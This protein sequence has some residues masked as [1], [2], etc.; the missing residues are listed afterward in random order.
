MHLHKGL[1]RLKYVQSKTDP[2]LYYR[3][4]T[5]LAIYI[6]DCILIAKTEKLVTEA[7][8]E[9]SLNF[10]ITDEGEVDEYLGV[11]IEVLKDKRVKMSQPF[12]IDQILSG[13]GFNERTKPKK[14]PAVSSKILH[15]DKGG[16]KMQTT[17][18]YRRIIGQLNFLEKSTRPDIAYA[19]HQCARF[20]SDPR[21]SHKMAILRIGRYL[22]ATRSEGIVFEPDNSSLELWC[23]ADFSGNWRE[24]IAHIDR[25][26]AK[27]RTG[28]VV[29]YAGC[30]LTWASKMQTE[31]ALSTT[32]AE[33]IALSEG[34]RTV[35]PIMSLLE[36]MQEQGVNITK[37][38][39]DIKCK[40]FEDNSGA[41]TIAT[42]PKI[43]PRTK[44]INT[45]YWHFREHM[46]Q[47]K[48]ALLPVST[49][50]QIADI[51]TKPLPEIDFVKLKERIMG[52]ER[53]HIC[54][55]SKG[56]VE[57]N[58]HGITVA[59]DKGI[60]GDENREQN[61]ARFKTGANSA[62][63]NANSYEKANDKIK[64][65]TMLQKLQKGDSAGH[66]AERSNA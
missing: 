49:K 27:S 36:E 56:S 40:V 52:K 43:R 28:F 18:E 1:T 20:S 37:S 24:D 48:I 59:K 50:D 33:F 30:P 57:I 47:G 63:P 8:K 53:G 58:E 7:V 10:E 60:P 45:K 51:L 17:W 41:L 15:Q 46:E 25:N 22:M 38:Q 16:E 42:L 9:L 54:S 11:K 2:C 65:E 13:L 14:T 29:K 3:K 39:A 31:T 35:I 21:A 23:D 55:S 19:V 61:S 66:N 26:T 6:D 5:M 4:D 62:S 44:Y 34:L 12:L 64:K 32:E